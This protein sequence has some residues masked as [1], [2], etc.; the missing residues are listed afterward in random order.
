MNP[1]SPAFQKKMSTTALQRAVVM[2]GGVGMLLAGCGGGGTE[3][4]TSPAATDSPAAAGGGENQVTLV[5][6]AVT[7]KAYEA[8]IPK[9]VADWKAKTGQEV[10]FKQSYGG[11]GS[12][13]RAVIDGLEAD[14]VA[15]ALAGDVKKI[16]Q[17]GLIDPGWEK[18]VPNDGIV[19]NSV[20]TFV[21]RPGKPKVEKWEQLGTGDFQIITANPKTS[22]GAKWNF[23]GL[24]GSVIQAGGDEAKAQ[25]FV[26]SVL[27]N[28]PIL[29]KDAR[30]STDVFYKQGQGDVLINYEN[31]I[32]L[33]K[34]NGEEQPYT[35]PTDINIRIEGPV[36]VVDKIVDKRGTRKIA[37]AFAQFLFTPDAQREFAKVGFRPVDPT[38]AKEFEKQF[39]PVTKLITVQDFGGWEAIDKKFFSDGGIFDK[40]QAAIAKP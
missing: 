9:F 31:E 40:T 25:A 11:S 32:L 27:R 17:A 5:S 29:P 1:S 10:S 2:I 24:W 30:E 6:Y 39:P 23:L 21:T 15:V 8:I 37:E 3:T 36:A 26:E 14:I 28:T 19:T 35:V 16:E 22:G 13:T 18:E 7:K 4:A 12:Q 34:L 33:A 38:V 20:V